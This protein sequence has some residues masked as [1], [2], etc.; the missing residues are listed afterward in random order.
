MIVKPNWDIFRVK[1]KDSETTN[2][3]YFCYLLFCI[4]FNRPYGIFRYKNQAGIESDPIEVDGKVVGFQSK[5]Y[6]VKLSNKKTDLLKML[7]TINERYPS[8]DELK[9][10]TNRDWGQGKEEND[11]KV[12]QEIY[13]KA[14]V[15]GINIEWRTD[16]AYFQSLDVSIINQDIASHF[17]CLESVFDI[18]EEK[19]NH[20]QRVLEN[21]N[22]KIQF[23]STAI[24][25]DRTDVLNDLKEKIDTNNML[26]VSGLGGVGKTAVIKK[27][28]EDSNE[29]IPFYIFK[30]NEFN[31]N[32]VNRLFGKYSL[33]KFIGV[34]KN[35]DEKII[36]ID[37]A[38]KLLDIEDLDVFKEFLS[39]F[40]NDN[41][42]V[43][44]TSRDHF[45]DV[46]N[47]EFSELLN[48]VAY[49]FYIE[50]ISDETLTDLSKEYKFDLP[51]DIK[52]EELIKNP[53]YLSEYLS[54][55]IKD[56]HLDYQS[57]KNKVW[58]KKFKTPNHE[59]CFL[60]LSFKRVS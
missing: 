43:I 19:K 50:N 27:F 9:L 24:E 13:E 18:V 12:K 1:F 20:T 47:N 36:V 55:Y 37:S 21:I 46:L 52:L 10:Y 7:D 44:F 30:A 4:E 3:E 8:L 25:L 42:K 16:E 33:E 56:E 29:D 38:E 51:N 23:N 2:F 32:D 22:N 34:H 60:E 45:V 58:K 49:N 26:I 5:F 39:T 6:D 35:Y 31:I 48:T 28:Y 54:S 53:F 41:W 15:Y 59:Q 14:D 11:S 57:F 40:N 17:F